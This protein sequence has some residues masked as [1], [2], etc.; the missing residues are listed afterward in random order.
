MKLYRSLI[1]VGAV[2]A[3]GLALTGAAEARDQIRIVGSSTVYPFTTAVAE[4]LGKTGGVKTPVVES[5]GTGGGM[6]LF[7]A[8]VGVDHPDATNASRRMKK[9]EFEQCQKNGVKDIVELTV[10]FDGISVAQSKAGA[11]LKLTLGQLFLAIAK[12]VPGADGKLVANPNKTWSDID[13]SLPNVKIEVLG[14]PPTS[15]TRDALHELLLEPGAEQIPAMKELKKADA[16]AFEK[17]WK[18]LR[19]DGAYV[20]AGENDN[21]IVQKL[22][23][24]KN[25]FGIFGFS[26]LEENAAKLR[27]VPLNTVEPTYDN[28]AGGQYPG[29]RLLYVYLKKQHVGVIPGLDKFAAEYVSNKAIGEDGY[30]AKKGLVTLPKAKA[31][32]VRKDIETLK[33]LTADPL[34]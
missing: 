33:P 3:T 13:K 8:G 5:T 7:C 26:F 6:K 21:V 17:A 30:L 32:A 4:Q 27:G 22:E 15:G 34:S 23:A 9:S 12:E 20:E 18:S 1:A 2:A 19:E 10:G 25:A 14:P 28:I 16:K 11:P 24:N 29:S 31:D